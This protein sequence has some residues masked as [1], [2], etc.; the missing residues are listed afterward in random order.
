MLMCV[1]WQ[2]IF[3]GDNARRGWPDDNSA[4]FYY[5]G[6]DSLTQTSNTAS[7][8]SIT[9][10][11]YWTYSS[12]KKWEVLIY[13][14]ASE[15]R[16]IQGSTAKSYGSVQSSDYTPISTS[17]GS[18]PPISRYQTWCSVP[19]DCTLPSGCTS[20]FP[21]IRAPKHALAYETPYLRMRKLELIHP[22]WE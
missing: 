4:A 20:H 5:T 14:R 6:V 11:P 2:L 10:T 13:A 18:P 7:G 21:K 12:T 17:Y 8:G 3:H 9:P 19:I 22:L 15:P 1:L 16:T